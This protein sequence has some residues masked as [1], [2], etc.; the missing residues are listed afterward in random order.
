MNIAPIHT[1]DLLGQAARPRLRGELA[2][3][4]LFSPFTVLNAREGTWQARKAAWKRM[5]IKSEL[6]RGANVLGH[7]EQ[8][9]NMGFYSAKRKL[10]AEL[11]RVLST[12][13]AG[14]LLKERG[15]IVSMSDDVAGLESDAGRADN[16]LNLSKSTDAFMKKE[17][18]YA[19]RAEKLAT[20]GGGGGPNSKYLK[21]GGTKKPTGRAYNIGLTGSEDNNWQLEDEHGSGTSIFDPVLCE[22]LY[23]WFS[24]PGDQIIDPFAGGS[25]RGIVAAALGRKY[26]GCDLS[27]A[28]IGANRSQVGILPPGCPTPEWTVG[29]ALVQVP[30]AP[31]ADAV[32]ACPPYFDLEVYSEDPDDLSQMTWDEFRGAYNAIIGACAERL[33]DD[34][35]AFFVTGD[36][37]DPKTGMYRDLPGL[38]A[39]C[40]KRAGMPLYNQMILVTAVGSLSIR[41]ERQFTV[42][43]KLGMTH[44]VVQVFCKG[45]PVKATDS[46]TGMTTE[47]RREMLTKQAEARKAAATSWN[48]AE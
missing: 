37:R 32:I 35:F 3:K 18:D 16:L 4:F 44:Q 41:T 38:T 36:I 46:A 43:R 31:D 48:D 7:S 40:F 8:S 17:G 10:E 19:R 25:V 2:K 13:E 28:Q 39:Q 23:S 14:A 45:D 22:L 24:K 34:R 27:A 33:R 6:G 26:W 20:P 42:S 1:T 12:Q 15:E 11:G 21:L 30:N 9:G 47:E 29:D 5:G